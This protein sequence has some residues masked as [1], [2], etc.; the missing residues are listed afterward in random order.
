[1]EDKEIEEQIKQF[2]EK[3]YGYTPTAKERWD[4]IKARLLKFVKRFT[5]SFILFYC[6]LALSF[7]YIYLNAYGE[8]KYTELLFNS[9]S[10]NYQ[11]T[12]EFALKLK[13]LPIVIR[14]IEKWSSGESD[15]ISFNKEISKEENK[16]EAIKDKAL[17]FMK[18][19]FSKNSV[20]WNTA[21]SY[22]SFKIF[23]PKSLWMDWF[24]SLPFFKSFMNVYVEDA[25]LKL[26]KDSEIQDNFLKE[27]QEKREI[28]LHEYLHYFFDFLNKENPR[29]YKEFWH[30]LKT[31]TPEAKENLDTLTAPYFWI[32][33]YSFISEQF[34]YFWANMMKGNMKNFNATSN[35]SIS[36]YYSKIFKN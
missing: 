22:I 36:F 5:I 14:H 35:P 26:A 17:G 4:K 34:A 7:N 9:L 21:G 13:H 19:L 29:F 31:L 16:Q 25:D 2:V 10:D 30:S 3:Q 18:L 27:F 23:K 11:F 15:A 12:E 33:D 1:M 24:I 20:N 8:E 32:D 28:V 6:I